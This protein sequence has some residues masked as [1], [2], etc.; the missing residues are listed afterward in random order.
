MF[1]IYSDLGMGKMHLIHQDT[2][3]GGTMPFSVIYVASGI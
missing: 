3:G 1:Y 2:I